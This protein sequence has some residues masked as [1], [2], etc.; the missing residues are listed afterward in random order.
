MNRTWTLERPF[1]RYARHGRLHRLY[2]E[3]GDENGALEHLAACRRLAPEDANL[4]AAWAS[5]FELPLDKPA[6]QAAS[7]LD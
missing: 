7:V 5:I 1:S 2:M 3:C 4:A 6:P